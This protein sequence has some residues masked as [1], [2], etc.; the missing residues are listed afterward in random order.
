MGQICKINL[1]KNVKL[2]WVKKCII[3]MGRNCESNMGQICKISLSKMWNYGGSK[4]VKL[5]WAK[6]QFN[7][8]IN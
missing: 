3:Y 4:N 6:C 5:M 8:G 7:L 2:R 1:C